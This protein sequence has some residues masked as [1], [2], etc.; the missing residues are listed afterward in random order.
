MADG[1]TCLPVDAGREQG[2]TRSMSAALVSGNLVQDPIAAAR[3]QRPLDLLRADHDRQDT[4]CCRLDALATDPEAEV[5]PEA[6]RALLAYLVQ[7]LPLHTRD[8]EEDLFPLLHKRSRPEDGIKEVLIQ[9]T[10][11]HALDGDLAGFLID[12]MRALAERITPS[13]PMRFCINARAFA[14]TQ[15]R[16][17]GWENR[18][19]LPLARPRL[20]P[21]DLA[22]MGRNMAARRGL[23]YPD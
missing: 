11:E 14:E 1:P 12:D 9:L 22:A 20:T 21:A 7:D 17:L 6:Y 10:R 19:V 15:R 3:F 23:A 13:P 5:E 18:L 2:E 4:F 8:E 16:H